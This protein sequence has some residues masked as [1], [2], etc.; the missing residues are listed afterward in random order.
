VVPLL[1]FLIV[2]MTSV[3]LK[4]K[5]TSTSPSIFGTEPIYLV[6]HGTD[7]V[8]CPISKPLDRWTAHIFLNHRKTCNKLI[9]VNHVILL[10]FYISI[11]I[12]GQPLQ[13][14]KK[15]VSFGCGVL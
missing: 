12:P 3:E 8:V 6:L 2:F 7:T 11:K 5:N 13:F 1:L 10:I 14:P 15:K 9:V 4:I